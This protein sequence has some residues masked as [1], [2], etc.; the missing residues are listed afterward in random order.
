MYI[1]MQ[2]CIKANQGKAFKGV[3]HIGA[4]HGEEIE[5]YAQTGIRDVLW[6]EANQ[7]MMKH[8][9]DK[10]RAYPVNSKYY[11]VALSNTDNEEVTLNIASNGQSSSLLEC[12]T[13]ATMYPHIT[14]TDR[15]TVKTRT[16][17][18]L[19][20]EHISDIDLDKYD[21]VNLD[22]QGA[23]LKVLEGFGP[24][25]DRFP[26]QAVYTEVNFEEVYEGCCLIED[27]DKFLEGHGF[28]RVL[29]AAPERTWGD[30]LYL[31]KV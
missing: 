17:E 9:Y 29:T 3:I 6:V 30:S 19:V 1:S 15:V 25:F 28:V 20:R 21:F 13:H 12:G 16:F 5:A 26:I 11:C 22:V 7:K 27:L 18:K 24:I 4:H 8:L 14:Y 2:E 31:R 10:T 23:E